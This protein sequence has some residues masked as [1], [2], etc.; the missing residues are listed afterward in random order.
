MKEVNI[1]LDAK[2]KEVEVLKGEME[3]LKKQ[4]AESSD[5]ASRHEADT[6]ARFESF[7]RDLRGVITEGTA[8]STPRRTC[9]PARARLHSV[10]QDSQ[11]SIA[12][13]P[14]IT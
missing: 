13:N 5:K 1:A 7:E 8:G 9:T 11:P 14:S 10:S 2:D 3:S 6:A 4:M 12:S